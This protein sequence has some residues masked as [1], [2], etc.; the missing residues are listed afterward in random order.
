V[1]S[2]ASDEGGAP[3]APGLSAPAWPDDPE[4]AIQI[5]VRSSGLRDPFPVLFTLQRELRSEL[6]AI[7][8]PV[9][10]S[11][12]VVELVTGE[13]GAVRIVPLG[14][15]SRL[16]QL[17]LAVLRGSVMLAPLCLPGLSPP[18]APVILHTGGRRI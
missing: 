16:D 11:A 4:S 17:V 14:C 15:C 9:H 18:P 2:S 12:P 8:C 1:G 7:R 10:E 6:D 13:V 3:R 5:H